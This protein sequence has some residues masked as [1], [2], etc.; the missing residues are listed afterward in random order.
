MTSPKIE[1]IKKDMSFLSG[2][3]DFFRARVLDYIVGGGW[4]EQSIESFHVSHLLE[5]LEAA[6]TGLDEQLYVLDVMENELTPPEVPEPVQRERMYPDAELKNMMAQMEMVISSFY[7]QAAGI[8]PHFHT[9]IEFAGLMV[10]FSNICK[11]TLTRGVD[12]SIA[13]R[14]SGVPLLPHP[15]Q[16]RYFAEKLEC[17]IG[18]ALSDPENR[19]IFFCAMGWTEKVEHPLDNPSAVRDDDSGDAGGE[20]RGV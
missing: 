8:K 20:F 10:E 17:I 16:I 4:L 5:G 11:Q 2:K 12:F 15:H 19:E 18:P 13:N 1:Q 9:F 14:H 7:G 6:Q 3:S